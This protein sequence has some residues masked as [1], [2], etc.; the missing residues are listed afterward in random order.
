LDRA[1]QVGDLQFYHDEMWLAAAFASAPGVVGC[2]I[3]RNSA[4]V[5]EGCGYVTFIGRPEA[6][7]ALQTLGAPGSGL[8]VAWAQPGAGAPRS[9]SEAGS[10]TTSSGAPTAAS[11]PAVGAGSTLEFSLFVGDVA[12]DVTDALL[13]DAFRGRY[14][15]VRSA[16]VVT[17]G[18][19]GRSKG[20]GFV[21]FSSAGERDDALVAMNGFVLCGRPLRISLA[22]PKKPAQG[23][24]GYRP[25]PAAAAA[26]F[27]HGAAAYVPSPP[28]A[29]AP[30]DGTSDPTNT[31]VF[32][33]GLDAAV[34]EDE[35]RSVFERFGELVYV[36]IP[37]GKNCGFVQFV[38]RACA[39]DAIAGANGTTVGRQ[40]VRLSWGRSNSGRGAMAAAAAAAATYGYGYGG[41]GYYG[42]HGYPQ[43]PQQPG[44]YYA[45][46]GYGY[47]NW[48]AQMAAVHFAQYAAA[49]QQ[50][51]AAPPQMSDA[52][53]PVPV[54]M[55]MPL[56]MPRGGDSAGDVGVDAATN[57]LRAMLLLPGRG[58]GPPLPVPKG[59]GPPAE[60]G[61]A[62][63]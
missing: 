12:P 20:F 53:A 54:S 61:D 21:R 47:E 1:A 41:Y 49:A 60:A 22:A 42:H 37:H 2:K 35:L 62:E 58:D 30:P 31:T 51:Y 32:V 6:E 10:S 46:P 57:A 11:G 55:P 27:F 50:G 45:Y 25:S 14:P 34:S 52:A 39:E 33:G 15:A 18:A 43:A 23:G 40:Q 19:S 9:T 36:K 16:K 7:A 63:A 5:S 17:D 38:H 29:A 26:A 44:A 4:G 3:A 13:A 56:P 48:G 8:R 59:A 28:G 24:P